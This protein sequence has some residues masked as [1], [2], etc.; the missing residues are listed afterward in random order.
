MPSEWVGREL[1]EYFVFERIGGGSMAEV[2][3]ALQPSMDRMVGIKILSAG[4]A[5]DPQFVARFRREVQIVASLEHPHILPVIDYGESDNTL[6]LVMRYVNGGTLHELI[7]QGPMQPSTVLR[8]LTEIGEAIDYAHERRVVHRDIKPRNVLLDQQG[9]P[10]IADFGLAKL[11]ESGGITNSGVEMIGT[12]HYMSPEQARGHPVDGRSDLY[13][14]GVLLFQMLTGR[15]PFDGDSTVGIVMK[16]INAPVPDVTESWPTLPPALNAVVGAGHGQAAGRPLPDGPGSH[17]GGGRCAGC[18]GAGG[19][20]RLELAGAGQKERALLALPAAAASPPGASSASWP[21]GVGR[22]LIGRQAGPENMADVFGRLF[23]TRSQRRVLWGGLLVALVSVFVLLSG[24]RGLGSAAAPLTAVAA[25]Q[26]A[27]SGVFAPA[28]R[29]RLRP[30]PRPSRRRLQPRPRLP[31][32]ASATTQ[33][34][35]TAQAAQRH[36]CRH[37]PARH[38]PGIRPRRHDAAAGAGRPI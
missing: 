33:P 5:H 3:K 30:A 13:S 28:A 8:Y 31:P 25:S 24:L 4:L 29:Q 21:S 6:Y 37:G 27:A 1:A 23:P 11:I 15:V 7:E 32:P 22:R 14:L 12:P 9:N 36:A 18:R 26:T 38:A 10:F 34:T 16:H 20:H 17:G 19:A 2:Y 35:A